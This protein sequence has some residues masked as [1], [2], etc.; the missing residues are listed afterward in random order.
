MKQLDILKKC[1]VQPCNSENYKG[2]V[3]KVKLNMFWGHI[4]LNLNRY[5]TKMLF[6]Y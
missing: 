4:C 2:G 5:Y 1:H 3:L 6:Q